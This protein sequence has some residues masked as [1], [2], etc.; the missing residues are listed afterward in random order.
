VPQ[1]V[2]KL[3]RLIATRTDV[4]GEKVAIDDELDA[5][6]INAVSKEEFRYLLR[7][8]QD[9]GY[10]D[11][12]ADT[13]TRLSVEGWQRLESP[14]GSGGIPGRCFVAMSFNP[15]LDDAWKLGIEPALKACGFQG[16]RVDKQEHN[17]DINDMIIAEVKKA[18]FVVADFTEHKAGVYFEAG[19]ARGL[20]RE[21]IWCC[22]KSDFDKTHFDTNHYSHI[23]WRGPSDLKQQ[24]VNRILATVHSAEPRSG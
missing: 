6:L 18:Q 1:K 24:L 17:R 9:N 4:A 23:I 16:V 10:I 8:L 13:S 5:P 3:L 11:H 15:E 12:I 22:R 2:E 7:Y 21:V 19:F 20:G 14:I